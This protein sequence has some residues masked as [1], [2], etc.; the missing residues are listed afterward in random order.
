VGCTKSIQPF[1][2][3]REP[4]AWPWCNLADRQRKP[5][6]ASVNILLSRGASQSAVRRRWLSFCTL[7]PSH[8]Q[9]SAIST[10]ILALGKANSRRKPTL[11]SRGA[12]RPGWYDVMW[13]FA[14]KSCLR[15]VEWAGALSWWSW[16]VQ[17]VIVN[18]TVTQYTN[19]VNGVSLPTD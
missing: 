11:G 12:E 3:S 1:W 5:Y 10:A 6:C 7:W 9:I 15:A 17:S 18:A 16:S 13:C 2:I 19:S 14:K 8:S 4:V